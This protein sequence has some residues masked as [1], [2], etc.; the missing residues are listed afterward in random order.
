VRRLTVFAAL[1]CGALALSLPGALAGGTATPGVTATSI[2]LGGTAPL[3]G[4][5]TAYAPVARGAQYYFAYVNDH[6]GVFKRK[7]NYKV[8]D[9]AYDPAKTI[10]ATRQLVQQDQVFA[11]FNSIGTEHVLT[12]RP[13]LNQIGVPQLFVGSGAD[14]IARE[15]SRYP[16]TMGYLPSFVGEGAIYGRYIAKHMRGTTIGVLAEDSEFG[17]ELLRGLKA[18]LRGKARIVST[19]TYEVTDTDVET[20]VVRLEASGAKTFMNFALPKQALQALVRSDKLGW[21]P[22]VF[23]TAVS[24]DPFVMNIARLNTGGRATN[25]AISLAFLKDPTD[26]RLAKDPGVKLYKS[27]MK[28]YGGGA[29]PKAVAHF[30]GMA[31]AFTMVD[32]LRHAGKNPTRKS[33]LRAATHLN[34]RNNPFLRRGVTIR[35]TP[36]DYFPI[37]RVQLQRYRKARWVP[38]GGI[39]STRG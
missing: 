29:E 8:L 24:I 27:I 1:G 34:E 37:D 38:I 2:L 18:G 25:G 14:V 31:V 36:K 13:F 5:E 33:L 28:K 12:V 11:I 6:G 22:R 17:D 32:A 15:R 9:D 4:P 23:I 39:V 19:Q 10:Q 7:I 21:H 20:Q 30:Y 26:S 35:T 16:W 3:T